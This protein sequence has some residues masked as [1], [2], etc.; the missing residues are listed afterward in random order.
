MS[1]VGA[2]LEPQEGASWTCHVTWRR[3]ARVCEGERVRYETTR[4]EAKEARW[5]HV[6]GGHLLSYRDAEGSYAVRLER[7]RVLMVRRGAV[8]LTQV[9]AA[10]KSQDLVLRAYGREL[11]V[12]AETKS[13]EVSVGESGGRS[14]VLF[15]LAYADGVLQS[16]DL[17]FQWVRPS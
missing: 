14:R 1:A 3:R 6:K 11:P 15:D 9:F 2:W 17:V 7:D 5:L 12:R 4:G 13:V 8:S 10:G 16:V